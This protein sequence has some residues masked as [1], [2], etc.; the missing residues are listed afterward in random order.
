MAKTSS[1][2]EAAVRKVTG[3]CLL[4]AVKV[5]PRQCRRRTSWPRRKFEERGRHFVELVGAQ[6]RSEGKD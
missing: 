1:Q 2:I 5:W 4:S 3:G 6:L